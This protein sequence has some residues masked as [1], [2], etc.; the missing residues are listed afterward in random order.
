MQEQ[1]H[2]TP[3]KYLDKNVRPKIPLAAAAGA[4]ATASAGVPPNETVAAETVTAP[5]AADNERNPESYSTDGQQM[6]GNQ[7]QYRGNP[8]QHR[9]NHNYNHSPHGGNHNQYRGNQNQY[10]GNQNQY[11][12]NQNQ[13]RGNQNGNQN[14]YSGN[15]TD[16]QNQYRG[17]SLNGQQN[18]GSN[19][20]NKFPAHLHP[21]QIQLDLEG[22]RLIE[23]FLRIN[24]KNYKDAF[25]SSPGGLT[26]DIMV[27]YLILKNVSFILPT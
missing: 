4:P 19:N 7:D 22:G 9:G 12:G 25:V 16:N 3:K 27:S 14:Q 17:Q 26:A 23:G 13:F 18:N 21:D 6:R 8:N 1:G 5:T 24:P 11:R 2:Q 20:R 10:R 15:Q